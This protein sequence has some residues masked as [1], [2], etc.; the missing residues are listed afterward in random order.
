MSALA[1]DRLIDQID[2]F[3]RK[4]YKNQMIKGIIWFVGIFLV[5]F[6]LT[7]TLEYFGRFGT[8]VR[9]VLFFSFILTNLFVFIK[10][11]CIPLS[12]LY[13]FGT[14]INRYQASHII[15]TFFPNVSDRL[16]NTLQ[17]NDDLSHQT[18]N[19]ELLR[20]SVSQRAESL[21]AIPFSD[22]IDVRENMKYVK[23]VTPVFLLF[24]SIAVFSP[25]LFTEGS[26]RVVNYST[27]YVPEAPF[28]FQLEDYKKEVAEGSD[29]QLNLKLVG[30][31]IPQ[32]VYLISPQG[33]QLMTISGRNT[34]SA[35]IPKV[36]ESGAFYFEANEFSSKDFQYSIFGRPV[37]GQFKAEIVYP[38][39]LGKS[40][41]IINNAG[42]MIVPEGATIIWNVVAKNTKQVSVQLGDSLQ[43][44]QNEGFRFQ[45]KFRNSTLVKVKMKGS[46]MNVTDS[47]N[48]NVNVIKD[49]HPSIQVEEVKDSLS[50]GLRFFSGQV[51]DDYGL[52]SLK[53][54]YTITSKDGKKRTESLPVRSVS[55][56]EIPF[57]FGVDFMREN[58]QL[59]DQI[60]YYFVVSDNDGVNGSKSTRSKTFTYKLPTLEELNQKREETQEQGKENIADL[61]NKTKDFQKDLERLQ[62]DL[63]NSKSNDW[64]Q[65]N[66]LN[67][68]KNQHSELLKSLE[69]TKEMLQNS[70]EE[71]QQLSTEDE[72]FLEKQQMIED[73]LN[74]LMDDELRKL[75]DDL[76]KLMEQNNKEGQQKALDEMKMSSEEMNKQLDRSLEMLKKMQVDEKIDAIEDELKK[77]AEQQEQLK[78]DIESKK[79]SKE[80]A[81]KKQ[82]DI[83]DK[84]N[85]LKDDLNQLD[86]LNQ[87]LNR[88]MDLPSTEEKEKSIDSEL[89]DAKENISKGKE[90]KAGQNQKSAAEQMKELA[91]QMDSAQQESNQQQQGEDMEL[92][93][94]ILESLVSLSLDQEKVMND[95]ASIHAN[96]PNYRKYSRTQRTIVDNT[97]PVSDSLYELAKRQPMLSKFVDEELRGIKSNQKLAINGIG[98]R[99]MREIASHQQLAMTSYNNLALMLNESLQQ[100]QKQMQQMKDGSGSC[101]KPG[102]SGKPGSGASQSMGN[103]K[104][105]LKKQLEQMEKGSNPNGKKPGDAPG[106]KPGE[107]PGEGAGI[108][109]GNKEIAKMAAE[110]NAIRQKLEQLKNELNKE[111]KGEGNQLNPLLKELEKQQD[112]LVNKR[113][114]SDLIRR[115]KDIL[116]RL[117]ESE[118]A[119][120]ER[121]FE[122]KRESNEGKNQNNSNLI[123]FDQY[124]KEKLKQIE[125]LRTVDP[126]YSKYYKDKANQYFNS[127]IE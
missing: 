98:E 63:L 58:V 34:F 89:N 6:L 35:T 114:S 54:V 13:S 77:L 36:S 109:L 19:I 39:Y 38:K 99:K 22:A 82:Q 80:E 57:D 23:W 18:G 117:L 45:K 76:E 112:D 102:G 96:D 67:Q 24:L 79:T 31:E 51:R 105:M 32:K 20:A 87:E 65:K 26:K 97:V 85:Q 86:K 29:I 101:E 118:K 115:Q 1:F 37:L 75:L 60:E 107:K 64:K 3:I 74:Q 43:T 93:R 33:K 16:L 9:A 27:V 100:M 42:D 122:E 8:P 61:L 104:E 40:N 4:F 113:F 123:R 56:L 68:L 46:Q 10:F 59:E 48:F 94:E 50:N 62:K 52:T 55:G 11:I 71:K 121:G 126:V 119:L 2:L 108:G 92:L 25:D 88:P 83:N 127:I 69:Q 124:N 73:L 78:K 41:E 66:Q 17:L 90:S 49:A 106:N 14:R 7:T 111:G 30:E 44:F 84:F 53:F 116:T 95:F 91:E 120:R 28:K 81:E 125:L 110:Q 103:M 70:S 47:L 21:S 15:G 5:T 12:K 72:S